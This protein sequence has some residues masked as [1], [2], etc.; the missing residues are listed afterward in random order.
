MP[1][2]FFASP[3]KVVDME[4]G[5]ISNRKLYE[6]VY[7]EAVLVEQSEVDHLRNCEECLEV[8]RILVRQQI[9]KGVNQ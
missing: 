8:I 4:S 9:S 7:E 1:D 3:A 2:S 6:L 5:H